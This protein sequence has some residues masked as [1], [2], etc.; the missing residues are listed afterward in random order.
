MNLKRII[1]NSIVLLFILGTF[2]GCVSS[3]SDDSGLVGKEYKDPPK[4]P[5]FTLLNQDGEAVSLS[6][7]ENMVVVVAF[8]YTSCPDICLAISA[9]MNWIMV[10]LEDKEEEVAF[11]SITIDPARDTVSHLKEWTQH[12][13]YEWNH[14]TAERP[15]TLM[16]VWDEWNVIVDNE[17]IEASV[18]PEGSSNRVVVMSSNNS[19][20]V[21]DY[22]FENLTLSDTIGDLDKAARNMNNIS[23]DEEMN[24]ALYFWDLESWNWTL[25]PDEHLNTSA[26]QDSHIAWIAEG[27]NTS[28]LPVGIDCNGNGWVMGEGSSSHC[29]CDEGYERPEGDILSC[30]LEGASNSEQQD[31]HAAALGEY[32]VGH[33]TVTWIID[34]EQRK[35]IFWTGT[36]WDLDGFAADLRILIEE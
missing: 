26:N 27:A 8:I 22:L 10:S 23:L 7:Y 33:S 16:R 30:T 31:A 4:A 1:T 2:S 5:D 14:L 3:G 9:N 19:I 35:R 24:W 21:T 28:L 36:N 6:D 34:K 11:I 29:M 15:S 20:E 12:M 13:G 25:A 17:H 18:P 32:E